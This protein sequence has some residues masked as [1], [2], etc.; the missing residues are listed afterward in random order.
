MALRTLDLFCKVI[1]NYGD[2]GIAW[3][4]ARQ[5]AGEHGLG[6]RLWLDQLP[7]LGKMEPRLD[8]ALSQQR[9]DGVEV[10]AWPHEFPEVAPHDAVVEAFGCPLPERYLAAMAKRRPPPVWINL[11]YLSAEAWVEGCHGLPSPHPRLPLT[12]YFFYPGFTPLTGGLL[13]ERD[14][15][16]KRAAARRNPAVFWQR[17][18]LALPAPGTLVVSLFCYA[19]PAL[20]ALLETWAGQ[21]RP[22]LALAPG[23][24]DNPALGGLRGT[25]PW[26][27]GS[28]SLHALPFLS[29]DEYDQLLW[30]CDLNF[31]RGEDSFVRAQWAA[32]PFV[33]HLYPQAER[34]HLAKLDAFLTRYTH[35]L[36]SSAAAA[37]KSFHGTWNGGA[38][39][40]PDW[41]AVADKLP[42]L[43]RHARQ[44]EQNLRQQQD[45]A[46]QLLTFINKKI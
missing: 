22:I 34:A 31:V 15:P 12:Q 36:P 35:T 19:N 23:G 5:L 45:L 41:L 28:L 7:V 10:R 39:P 26:H 20:P 17:L 4:M 25:G 8:P 18:G 32:R 30:A 42:A 24:A 38:A 9:I 1:D 27:E 16:L 37:L 11:E 6:V 13:R 46:S 40:V 21:A 44:W 14:L 33:W 3:R 43:H 29:Q 2:A